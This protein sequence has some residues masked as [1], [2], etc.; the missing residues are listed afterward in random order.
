[1]REN[2]INVP[3]P[4]SV[5]RGKITRLLVKEPFEAMYIH[6]LH[7][8]DRCEVVSFRKPRRYIPRADA[9]PLL[10]MLVGSH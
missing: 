8:R 2:N 10:G 3:V 5:V 7:F 9:K 1:M 4:R 6:V